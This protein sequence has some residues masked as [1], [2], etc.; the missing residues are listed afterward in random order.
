MMTLQSHFRGR[1]RSQTVHH[2]NGG[3]DGW[4]AKICT[5]QYALALE[6]PNCG[7]LSPGQWRAL[8]IPRAPDRG[9]GRGNVSLGLA[10]WMMS[11]FRPMEVDTKRVRRKPR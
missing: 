2:A 6:T 8:P 7:P 5:V 3:R 1:S 10:L 9:V 11:L 4:I